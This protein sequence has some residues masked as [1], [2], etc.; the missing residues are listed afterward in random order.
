MIPRATYRV[1]LSKQFGFHEV[2]S[3]AP[4]LASLGISHVYASPYLRARPGSQHGYDVTD[5]CQF[6]PE[7]GDQRSFVGMT[8]AF[9]RSGLEHI[10]DFVP[11]HMGVGG[12][13]NPF[14]LD[15]LEWGPESRYGDWFDIDWQSPLD[16]LQGKVLVPFLADQYGIELAGGKLRLTFDAEKGDFAVWLY[17]THKLPVA[18]QTYP[19]I[20]GNHEH[21]AW[22]TE[23]CALSGLS[24]PEK[25][26]RADAVKER[27]SRTAQTN[28]QLR[29]VIEEAVDKFAGTMQEAR[30]WK[31]LAELIARQN[32]RPAYYRVAADTINYR[33]FF[34]INELAGVRMELPAVFERAHRFILDLLRKEQL[35]GLRIDHIDGLFD[36]KQYLERLRKGAGT[37]AYIIVE[38][39]LTGSEKLREDWP[40]QG[41][42]GYE[43]C[44]QVLGLL[45]DRESEH[46]LTEFYH[47]FCS[48]DISFSETV[49]ASKLTILDN[50]LAG[51]L[52]TLSFAAASIARQNCETADFTRHILRRALRSI[53][54]RFPVYRTYID[55]GSHSD[56]DARY[57]HWAISQGCKDEPEVDKSV[58]QF[59]EILLNGRCAE[60]ADSRLGQQ[61]IIFAMKVQQLSGPVMAK[62]SEDTAL[63]RYNRFIALNEVGGAPEQ[64]GCSL[65][66]FHKENRH[67]AEA[68]PHT[69]LATSTH[70]TKHGEDARARLAAISLY[71]AQWIAQVTAWSRLLRAR[72]GDIEGIAPPT[73]SDEYLFYQNLIATWPPEFTSCESLDHAAWSVYTERIQ[74]GILKSLREARTRT[75]WTSP[76]TAYEAR[77]TDFIADALN[78][79]KSDVFLRKFILF[80]RRIARLGMHNSL[81]QTLLK[82]CS[83]GQPDFYQGSELWDLHLQDP[84]NR[85]PVDYDRRQSMLVKVQRRLK[86][87]RAAA[88]KRFFVN[89]EDG[90]VKLALTAVLLEFRR[91]KAFLFETGSYE[92]L[93]VEDQGNS[94]VCAFVRAGNGSMF[95]SVA[96]LDGR[97]RA[98]N[99]TKRFVSPL[100]SVNTWLEVITDRRIRSRRGQLNLSEV[101]EVLPVALLTPS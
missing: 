18:P 77:V 24:R 11:N 22:L 55:G 1:Q 64:F 21:F 86:R 31:P 57:I 2:A 8:H 36:P 14:W 78:P 15:V 81:V 46:A 66:R 58:F 7:L 51:E 69:M 41:T 49:R 79:E 100:E 60:N 6:N 34:N 85:G 92:P 40:V 43:F 25:W 83:P 33:R 84:D 95:V 62:G 56:I 47:A 44:N 63:Y 54:A 59:L 82:I 5:Y 101:F 52:E 75:N 97:L 37:S 73:R 38:K 87:G 50:E 35:Q 19:Q 23:Q 45:I 71:P 32:W 3:I 16:Q 27:L 98:A 4:Y 76:D 94:P 99:F 42:T 17:E 61:T 28:P 12:A 10:V 80:Q 72:R 68:W 70:D 29:R 26:R 13:D 67:H 91:N 65:S 30:S 93:F 88:F 96:L 9:R 89:W 74:N 20:C 39:I 48:E 90:S 53:V